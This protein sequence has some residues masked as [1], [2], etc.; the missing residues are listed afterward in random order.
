MSTATIPL[1]LASDEAP[2]SAFKQRVM[3]KQAER[4]VRNMALFQRLCRMQPPTVIRRWNCDLGKGP[5]C[6]LLRA[7]EANGREHLFL[8]RNGEPASLSPISSTEAIGFVALENMP[9]CLFG[10]ACAL[11]SAG[12]LALKAQAKAKRS[13]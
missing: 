9:D 7:V 4:R 11:L 2:L 8:K 1:S 12:E 5:E 3:Q 10:E 6:L 13:K